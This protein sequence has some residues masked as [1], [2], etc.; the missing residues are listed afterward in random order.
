MKGVLIVGHGSRRKETEETMESVVETARKKLPEM[1]VEIAYMEFG[2]K[3]IPAGLDIL[4]GK[5]AEEIVVAPYFL[6]DGMHIQKDI[7]EAL[8]E[9]KMAHPGLKITMGCPLGADERLGAVLAD[10]VLECL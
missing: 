4:A 2:E 3:N 5:G 9:Y 10:R 6:F 8:E 7:P 1:P